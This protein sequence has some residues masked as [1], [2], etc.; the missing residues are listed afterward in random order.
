M[1]QNDQNGPKRLKYDPKWPKMAL[2]WP[3]MIQS[4]PKMTQNGPQLP[5]MN[6]K[7]RPDLRTLWANLS[8]SRARSELRDWLTRPLLG[9]P[10][11]GSVATLYA[12]LPIVFAGAFFSLVK[13]HT[14]S[15]IC[16]ISCLSSCAIRFWR[17]FSY[18]PLFVPFHSHQ[19]VMSHK[20]SWSNIKGSEF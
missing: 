11:R 15:Q 18:F 13:D 16:H 1:A 6:Q 12:T 20:A 9:S 5:Q 14:L 8:L 17:S 3:K 10:R 2:E 4:G 7:W 19:F